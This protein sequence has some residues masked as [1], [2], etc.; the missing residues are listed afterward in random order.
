MNILIIIHKKQLTILS[1]KIFKLPK[2]EMINKYFDHHLTQDKIDDV[3][4]LLVQ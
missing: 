1:D 4:R 2:T 3:M